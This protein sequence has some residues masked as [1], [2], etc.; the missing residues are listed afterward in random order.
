MAH[1]LYY[2]VFNGAIPD[3]IFALHKCDNPSCVNPDHI[4]LGTKKDNMA[5]CKSKGRM[6]SVVGVL[7]PR[8][9]LTESDVLKIKECGI[10]NQ[11]LTALRFGVSQKAVWNIVHGKSWTH[12]K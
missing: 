12:I 10:E 7:N 5:D 6:A 11:R 2:T 8:R 9:K 1:R 4:F 3:G